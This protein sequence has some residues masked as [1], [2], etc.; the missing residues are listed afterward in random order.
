MAAE[1]RHRLGAALPYFIAVIL[2]L[3]SIGFTVGYVAQLQTQL[4]ATCAFARDL[5]SASLPAS[6]KPSKLG[7]SIVADSRAQW[8]TLRCPGTLP[9]APGLAHWAA[10]YHLDGR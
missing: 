7:V 1:R 6:P 10:A 3:T 5:G 9:P 4:Q 2:T 8:R